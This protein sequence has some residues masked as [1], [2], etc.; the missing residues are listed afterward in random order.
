[1]AGLF[2][3]NLSDT[4][5]IVVLKGLPANSDWDRFEYRRL[6]PPKSDGALLLPRE[7]LTTPGRV[8]LPA[9][10]FIAVIGKD[11]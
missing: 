4:P 3:V 11:S 10:A 7:V 5:V 6:S 9:K 8:E 1:V 2:S